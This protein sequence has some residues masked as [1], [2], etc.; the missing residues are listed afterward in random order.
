MRRTTLALGV[1]AGGLALWPAGAALASHSPCIPSDQ[2]CLR[3]ECPNGDFGDNGWI[4]IDSRG[5]PHVD[6]TDCAAT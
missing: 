2:L 6:F 4:Y 1:V 5:F 3:I